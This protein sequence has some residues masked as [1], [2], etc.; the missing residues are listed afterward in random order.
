MAL[1]GAIVALSMKAVQQR[2]LLLAL[3]ATPYFAALTDSSI[4]DSNEAFYAQTPREMLQRSDWVTPYFNGRP[5]LNKP[6]LA[7]WAVGLFYKL[8]GVS[9]FWERFVMAL[10]A[11]G[12]VGIVFQLGSMLFDPDAALLSA[13]T[14]ATTFRF[15]VLSRRLLIDMLM[16]FFVLAAVLFFLRWLRRRR[17]LDF[18]LCSAALGL[19]FLAKGPAAL[20][21]VVLFAFF[22]TATGQ[23]KLIREMPLAPAALIFLGL[24]LPWFLLLGFKTGWDVVADF[25]LKENLGRFSHLDY[26]PRR[27]WHYYFGVFLGDFFPWSLFFGAAV[28][29]W[30]RD[31]SKEAG[32]GERECAWLILGWVAVWFV[33]FSL[34]RNKQEYY[35]LPVY[36]AAALWT[37]HYL[38]NA[39]APRALRLIASGLTIAVAVVL[40]LLAGKLFPGQAWLWAPSLTLVGFASMSAYRKWKAAAVC[41]SLFFA[42]GFL[43]FLQPLEQYRPVHHLAG[44]IERR[45]ADSKREWSAGYYRFTAPSLCFYLNRTIGEFYELE[46]AVRFLD[47]ERTAYLIVEPDGLQEL[48]NR[49]RR[50]LTVLDERPRLATT[51]R[52][53]L[54]ALRADESAGPEAWTRPVYLVV[55]E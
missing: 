51:G 9:L 10:L 12:C 43:V 24:C 45:E 17:R 46:E 1:R 27:A 53:L 35:I 8:F 33:L 32:E 20:L 48:R 14:L 30:F 44:V 49:S 34:S 47:Q 31:R 38:R 25:F 36:P 54:R 40:L 29:W 11:A 13:G 37:G 23:W 21:P 39:A 16:L 52:S 26:G 42:A 5:R 4:W 3:F 55:N 15:A 22:L 50:P 28:W 6:P 2:V 41:L 19:G 7:Y 18:F